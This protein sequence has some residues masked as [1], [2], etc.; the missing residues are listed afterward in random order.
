LR[1]ACAISFAVTVLVAIHLLEMAALITADTDEV[2][3]FFNKAVSFNT[4]E[5]ALV[6]VDFDFAVM[7]IFA[8]VIVVAAEVTSIVL[9]V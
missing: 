8:L 5:S 1:N 3:V 4:A 7:L 6:A 9:A 2:E